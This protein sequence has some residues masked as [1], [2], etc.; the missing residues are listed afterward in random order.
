[1]E[2]YG[3]TD[4]FIAANRFIAEQ[5]L[6]GSSPEALGLGR[7]ATYLVEGILPSLARGT[8]SY[9]AARLQLLKR[10]AAQLARFLPNTAA[11]HHR[12]DPLVPFAHFQ[13]LRAHE[14][15]IGGDSELYAYEAECPDTP[16]RKF[17]GLSENVMPGNSERTAAFL[18]DHMLNYPMP[19]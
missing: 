17:H 11:H 2:Y 16:D 8:L 15:E 7:G 18:K 4:F 13:S 14:A 1:M 9:E 12:C 6:A 10:S 5:Y 19:N 3:P